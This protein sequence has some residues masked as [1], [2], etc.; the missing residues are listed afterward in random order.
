MLSHQT[1]IVN[2]CGYV[3]YSHSTAICQTKHSF[4]CGND[5]ITLFGTPD[6]RARALNSLSVSYWS[7]NRNAWESMTCTA[8]IYTYWIRSDDKSRIRCKLRVS[9]REVLEG[10]T[11]RVLNVAKLMSQIKIMTSTN[12]VRLSRE[13]FVR[14]ANDKNNNHNNKRDGAFLI[15]YITDKVEKQLK[16]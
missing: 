6:A 9:I 2:I 4:L 10:V 11:D 5:E 13:T 8:E 1:P 12:G 7:E 3:A 14:C 16:K 15:Y